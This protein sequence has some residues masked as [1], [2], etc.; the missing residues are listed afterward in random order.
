MALPT[1]WFAEQITNKNFLS[2]IG[3]LFLLDKAK[4]CSFLCQK[5][6]I[7]TF[8]INDIDIPTRGL[9]PIPLESTANYEDLTIEFIVDEDLRNYMEIHNWMRAMGT[10]QD[11]GERDDWNHTYRLKGSNMDSKVSDATLQVLNNNNIANFDVVFKSVFPVELS[12]LPFDV[13]QTDNNYFTAMATFR[14]ILYEVRD[15]SSGR[16]RR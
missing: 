15:P 13:T 16:M 10:P 5:A 6:T 14:Y 4:N 1:N 8:R 9:V 12:A 11:Y 3:F 2:P 7:P